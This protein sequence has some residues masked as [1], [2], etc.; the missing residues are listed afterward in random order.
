MNNDSNKCFCIRRYEDKTKEN[1]NILSS[2][3]KCSLS[4]EVIFS[5]VAR[6]VGW[7]GCG[8]GQW[9]E[10]PPHNLLGMR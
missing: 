5:G 6:G 4:K 2:L 10:C 3:P 7:V 8:E 9:A 1:E